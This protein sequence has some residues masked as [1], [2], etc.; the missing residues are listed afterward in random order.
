MQK[1]RILVRVVE[2]SSDVE[3]AVRLFARIASYVS[4]RHEKG[5]KADLLKVSLK[6]RA[7][8]GQPKG[9][10]PILQTMYPND[11][12]KRSKAKLLKESLKVGALWR[13]S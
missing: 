9:C 5:S 2:G 12:R 13:Q 11:T 8:W 1:V 7:R 3:A 10:L 6:V 4:Q